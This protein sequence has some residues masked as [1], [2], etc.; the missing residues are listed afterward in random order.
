[1]TNQGSYDQTCNSTESQ[2]QSTKNQTILVNIFGFHLVVQLGD[3][4]TFETQ[5][6][7]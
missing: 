1:M 7:L 2:E 4:E 6:F 3:L 5:S